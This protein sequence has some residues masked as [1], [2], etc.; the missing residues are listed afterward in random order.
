MFLKSLSVRLNGGQW[1]DE[2]RR[3]L[4]RPDLGLDFASVFA[5]T[6]E[7]ESMLLLDQIVALWTTVLQWLMDL[8]AESEVTF[9][10]T[11]KKVGCR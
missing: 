1:R 2:I 6:T 9:G 11:L 4:T 5:H 3:Q 8:P 10:Y 7:K